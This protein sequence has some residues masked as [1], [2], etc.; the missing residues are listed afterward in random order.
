MKKKEEEKNKELKYFN[1]IIEGNMPAI[2]H[3]KVLAESAD[4]A[5]KK[6]ESKQEKP[7]HIDYKINKFKKIKCKVYELGSSIIKFMKNWV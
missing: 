4:E 2:F 5:F 7:S 3:Y 1:V 6:I